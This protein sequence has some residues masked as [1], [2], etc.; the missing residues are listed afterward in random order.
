MRWF[1]NRF[2]LTFGAIAIIVAL[3][4]VYVASHDEG[5]IEGRVVGPGGAPVA[6]ATV[7]L[8]ERTLLVARPRG[9][10]QTDAEGKFEFTGHDLHHLFLE[11]EK[12]GAGRADPREVRLYFK[13]ENFRLDAP[14]ELRGDAS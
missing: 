10:T 6:G 2:V 9:T 8:T 7:T 4:N 13:G 5:L 11:A 14:L 1:A 12:P 3:W